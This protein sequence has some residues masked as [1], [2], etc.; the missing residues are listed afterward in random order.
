MN[1]S[2][3]RVP[4]HGTDHSFGSTAPSADLGACAATDAAITGTNTENRRMRMAVSHCGHPERS[5]G[6]GPIA[7]EPG[8]CT[9]LSLD[10]TGKPAVWQVFGL[11]GR[12]AT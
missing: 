3:G 1:A 7:L 5:E 9:S 10:K 8:P 2:R 4:F 11:T 12:R 6:S